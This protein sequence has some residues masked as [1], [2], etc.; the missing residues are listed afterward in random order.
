M[1]QQSKPREPEQ[2]R[3]I[4][5]VELSR[6][7]AQNQPMRVYDVRSQ[8]EVAQGLIPGARWLPLHLIPMEMQ[9]LDGEADGQPLVF[10]CQT[11]GRSIQA[12]LYLTRLG[13]GPVYNL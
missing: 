9:R 5:A 7:L 3:E 10:Y 13:V 2:I 8:A 1:T 6:W 4:D 12:C 11:G